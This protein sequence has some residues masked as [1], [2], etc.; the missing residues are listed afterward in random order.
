MSTCVLLSLLWFSRLSLSRSVSSLCRLSQPAVYRS[1]IDD[2]I[3]QVRPEFE[4]IGVEEA[5]LQELLRLWELKLAQSR[6]ADFSNDE[7]MGPVAG[8]FL[9]LTQE[10]VALNQKLLAEQQTSQG[11]SK[12]ACF[13]PPFT[14]RLFPDSLISLVFLVVAGVGQEGRRR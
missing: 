3:H 14:L 9:P 8:Q 12:P 2:V 1:I 13:S 10:E 4:Q 6:V 5:V 11:G 7:R